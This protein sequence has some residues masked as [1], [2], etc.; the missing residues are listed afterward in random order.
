MKINKLSA[1]VFAALS[2]ACS[3]TASAGSGDGVFS[4]TIDGVKIVGTSPPAPLRN[5]AEVLPIDN[6]QQE[7][8]INLAAFKDASLR[9]TTYT[10][11][12]NFP[13]KTGIYTV[14]EKNE[15]DCGC[16][17]TLENS[18]FIQYRGGSITVN[19]QSLTSARVIATFSGTLTL[20]DSY[21]PRHPEAKAQVVISDGKL[22]IPV[23]HN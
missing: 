13:V 16:H 10:L 20:N 9:N 5:T 15:D 12:F 22:D 21:K 4:A 1:A 3:G 18:A 23:L 11:V 14:T 17:L 6:G 19:I 2:I 8:L 7:L